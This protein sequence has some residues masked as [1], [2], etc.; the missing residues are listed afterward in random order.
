[1]RHYHGMT[2]QEVKDKFYI[3]YDGE[4][5][6]PVMKR[7]NGRL[8]KLWQEASYYYTDSKNE[9]SKV[10]NRIRRIDSQLKYNREEIKQK[11]IMENRSVTRDKKWT[12]AARET[13][14]YVE[15]L[16]PDL[17][18]DIEKLHK[19]LSD[20]SEE[21]ALWFEI[22]NNLKFIGERVDS[23]SMNTAVEAKMSNKEPSNIP[24]IVEKETKDPE[25]DTN[26]YK[27]IDN[28]PS[29]DEFF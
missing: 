13:F 26:E 12:D 19:E 25:L 16:N 23:S 3:N 9:M 24:D 2:H 14:A 27:V 8:S 20:W 22:M 5:D 29:S 6:I 28:K 1:M 18:G 17:R 11:Y 7:I 21:V 10:K 15:S 4:E